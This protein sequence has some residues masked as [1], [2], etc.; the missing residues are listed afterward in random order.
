ME[1]S[2][3]RLYVNAVESRS[4]RVS[5]LSHFTQAQPEKRWIDVAKEFS[6]IMRQTAKPRPHHPNLKP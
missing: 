3:R 5:D 1:R 6:Y 2:R 4:S